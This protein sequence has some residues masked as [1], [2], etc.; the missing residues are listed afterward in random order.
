MVHPVAHPP[1]GMAQPP[2]KVRVEIDGNWRLI[3]RNP[4]KHAKTSHEILVVP[5]LLHPAKEIKASTSNNPGHRNTLWGLVFEPPKHLFRMF[6]GSFFRAFLLKKHL[7]TPGMEDLD[8]WN[9]QCK[10]QTSPALNEPFVMLC[11]L[12]GAARYLGARVVPGTPS[13][14]MAM[15]WLKYKQGLCTNHWTLTWDDPPI[16]GDSTKLPIMGQSCGRLPITIPIPF[17]YLY[18][19]LWEVRLIQVRLMKLLMLQ[20]P[21]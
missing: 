11:K 8:G 3:D 1:I 7:Q 2:H 10:I 9:L 13:R 5:C 4:R 15:M 18:G 19:F 14:N 16:K 21:G 20:K 12:S 17:P 6:F